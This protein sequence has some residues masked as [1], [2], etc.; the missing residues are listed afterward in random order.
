MW[1]LY[2]QSLCTQQQWFSETD[3]G[4][5]KLAPF[6]SEQNAFYDND[7]RKVHFHRD[8]DPDDIEAKNKSKK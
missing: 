8:H 3:G 2:K 1:A 6:L 5:K 7:R 4:K